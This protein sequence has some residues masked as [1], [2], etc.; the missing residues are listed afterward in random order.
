[1]EQATVVDV[2]GM[3]P[4]DR[5]PLIFSTFDGMPVGGEMILVNDHDPRPLWYQFLMERKDT[6]DWAYQEEGPE[7]WKVKIT[8]TA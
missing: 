5:H 1:M 2:R 3:P 7:V 6:F 8:K 4:R